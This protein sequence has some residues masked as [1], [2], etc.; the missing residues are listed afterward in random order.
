MHQLL[1]LKS[2]HRAVARYMAIGC[3]L[4]TICDNYGL[5]YSSW[6]QITQAPLFRE[7]VKRIELE[8]ENRLVEESV[9]DRNILRMKLAST[10]AVARLE[11]EM[12]NIDADSG[13]S[14]ATR[15]K[16]ATSIL[17]RVGY[18]GKEDTGPSQNVVVFEFSKEKL[19]AVKSKSQ[20]GVQPEAVGA[21]KV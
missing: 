18:S 7:E 10:R 15:I 19:E 8:I 21:D 17:D 9:T 3:D 5:N 4:K 6:L 11:A 14:A 2:R 12:D 20:V 1:E 13:A 16:A